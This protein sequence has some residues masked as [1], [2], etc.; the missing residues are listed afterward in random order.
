MIP[1]VGRQR[2]R[3]A[4]PGACRRSLQSVVPIRKRAGVIGSPDDI[5]V[6][7]QLVVDHV[8]GAVDPE[9]RA[10]LSKIT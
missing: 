7:E 9:C 5:E 1:L 10:P 3:D 4:E 8:L 6:T 2:D